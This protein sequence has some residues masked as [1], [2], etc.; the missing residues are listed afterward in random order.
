MPA[1][2]E[3]LE[4]ASAL[5]GPIIIVLCAMTQMSL[6]M[7][8]MSRVDIYETLRPFQE[9]LQEYSA[10]NATVADA[11]RGVSAYIAQVL[12]GQMYSFRSHC[13]CTWALHRLRCSV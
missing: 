7:A 8:C 12:T 3:T 10:M 4:H 13:V 9:L 5:A 1:L 6:R 11:G 2:C